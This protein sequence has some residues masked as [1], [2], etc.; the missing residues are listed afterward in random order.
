MFFICTENELKYDFFS[1]FNDLPEFRLHSIL[2]ATRHVLATVLSL[3]DLWPSGLLLKT[4][5]KISIV[6]G[7]SKI[8]THI[9]MKYGGSKDKRTTNSMPYPEWTTEA[10]LAYCKMGYSKAQFM[11]S[12][13]IMYEDPF[14]NFA[15]LLGIQIAPLMMTLVRK[16]KCD[17]MM[18]HRIYSLALWIVHLGAGVQLYTS[19]DGETLLLVGVLT[20][21]I[22][23]G[24]LEY[25]FPTWML[26]TFHGMMSCYFYPLYIHPFLKSFEEIKYLRFLSLSFLVP[27]LQQIQEIIDD[28]RPTI[29]SVQYWPLLKLEQ[30]HYDKGFLL[31]KTPKTT[32]VKTY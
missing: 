19:G 9:T 21:M 23:K 10:Q 17:A 14:M 13:G 28:P 7:T 6:V 16:N 32:C 8:A 1:Y 26:W 20:A 15:P 18:V 27:V 12:V 31:N 29:E 24:R 25:G 22:M 2:F 30:K 11:A 5:M 4:L 3:N